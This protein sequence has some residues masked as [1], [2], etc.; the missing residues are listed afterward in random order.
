MRRCW[1]RS[2]R[3]ILKVPPALARWSAGVPPARMEPDASPPSRRREREY[4]SHR[5]AGETPALLAPRMTVLSKCTASRCEPS[6]RFLKQGGTRNERA[7]E[8]QLSDAWRTGP[9]PALHLPQPLRDAALG[10][11]EAVQERVVVPRHLLDELDEEQHLGTVDH[12]MHALLIRLHRVEARV[13]IA[14]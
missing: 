4:L 10:L 2:R 6:D 7:R 9:P 1:H 13:G 14:D 11:A 3:H 12:Q 8:R 5:P